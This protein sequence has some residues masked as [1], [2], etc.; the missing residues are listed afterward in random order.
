MEGSRATSC[1]DSRS[2]G[3][4]NTDGWV[5]HGALRR[6]PV[7]VVNPVPHQTDRAVDVALAEF[8]SLRT[9]MAARVNIQAA[10]VGVALTAIGVIFGLVLDKGGNTLLLLAVPPL[11]LIVN[12]LHL[13]ESHRIGLIMDY[14]DGELW[15]YLQLQVGHVPSWEGTVLARQWTPSTVAVATLL[16]GAVTG[17]LLGASI[18]A[19]T[20]TTQPPTSLFV[21]DVAAT[22][23]TLAIPLVGAYV[24]RQ[25][26]K[27]DSA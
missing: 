4:R 26:Q 1:S 11:A 15:P 3:L 27:R 24:Q 6:D 10:L 16:D 18:L 23:L 17:L 9:E 21:I 12:V 20:F 5:D 22:I 14:I 7:D 8:T 19:L 2:G 25:R 13:A